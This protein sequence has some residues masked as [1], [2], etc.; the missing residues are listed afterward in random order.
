MKRASSFGYA[1]PV[2][3][4]TYILLWCLLLEAVSVHSVS[5]PWDDINIVVVTDVHSWV[6]G[7]A[8]HP[9]WSSDTSTGNNADYGHLLSFYRH[10]Q[11]QA[12]T[13]GTDLFFVMNGDFMDGTGLSSMI[14]SPNHLLPILT[15]MPWDAVNIGNHELYHNET[16]T[17]MVESGFIDH[18]GGNYLTSNVDVLDVDELVSPSTSHYRPLGNSYT[19]LYGTHTNTTILTFGFLYNFE[20]NCGLTRVRT[21][22]QV[23]REEWFQ[24]VLQKGN[25]D[26]ILVLA[27]MDYRDDLVTVILQGIREIVGPEIPVQF[28]NGHSHIRGFQSLDERAVS[29]EAGHFLDT[30]GFASFSVRPTADRSSSGH[31][32][33]AFLDVN[34]KVL[35][36]TAQVKDL[37]TPAGDALSLFIRETQSTLGLT[38]AIGCAPSTY[39]LPNRLTEPNSL[40]RLFLDEVVPSQL[41]QHNSSK[42]YVENTGA[43]RFNL[44]AG[45]VTLNDLVAVAPFN[46]TIYRIAERISG[47]DLRQV[48]DA[49]NDGG[50]PGRGGLPHMV[51]SLAENI[52]PGGLYDIFTAEFDTRMIREKIETITSVHPVLVPLYNSRNESITTT[53]LWANFVRAEFPCTATGTDMHP[54]TMAGLIMMS[55]LLC[56]WWSLKQRHRLN[57][58]LPGLDQPQRPLLVDG[59]GAT[60]QSYYDAI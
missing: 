11:N 12:A 3:L 43:F 36:E 56:A 20:G 35:Q 27:H 26:A 4:R 44:F 37:S 40:W 57:T 1:F 29:F 59:N 49:L 21:V 30:I 42:V 18:W 22:Q 13:K 54:W 7:H 46:D 51:S 15:R 41:F 14:P 34:V 58:A 47:H 48:M 45:E 32:H 6:G 24:S 33:H 28:I 23:V 16:I 2:A 31:F 25:F 38:A 19:Y 8:S 5:L 55:V 9:N 39:Y 10:L 53:T 52:D 60:S 50:D 17:Y